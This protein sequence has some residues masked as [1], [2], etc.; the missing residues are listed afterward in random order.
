MTG[1]LRSSPLRVMIITYTVMKT[2]LRIT[3]LTPIRNHSNA[4]ITLYS[5]HFIIHREFRTTK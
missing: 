5:T 2:A 3:V 4:A 1:I